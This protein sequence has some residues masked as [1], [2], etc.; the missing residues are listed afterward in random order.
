M[1]TWTPKQ[2]RGARLARRWTQRDLARVLGVP[3]D[4]V[5]NYEQGRRRPRGRVL[6]ILDNLDLIGDPT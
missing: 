6:S 2:I 4:S 5:Q 3:I 1:K